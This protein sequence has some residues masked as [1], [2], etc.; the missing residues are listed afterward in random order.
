VKATAVKKPVLKFVFEKILTTM[1]MDKVQR[2]GQ[3]Y[4]SSKEA[5]KNLYLL[6]Y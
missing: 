4:P 6:N 2:Q 3:L 1:T 5:F